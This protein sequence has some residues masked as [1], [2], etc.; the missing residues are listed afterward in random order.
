MSSR[1]L[2][3]V[4]LLSVLHVKPGK[5]LI[6][7]QVFFLKNETPGN[8]VNVGEK[9]NEANCWKMSNTDKSGDKAEMG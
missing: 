2:P 8:S 3:E 5:Q 9:N 6:Q 1:S 7:I 4:I